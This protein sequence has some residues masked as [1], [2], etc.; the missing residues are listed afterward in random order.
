MGLSMIDP[1]AVGAWSPP[2]TLTV[3]AMAFLLEI[4]V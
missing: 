1:C 4:R 3:P 2:A